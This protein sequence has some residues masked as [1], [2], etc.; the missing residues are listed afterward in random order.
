MQLHISRRETPA[1]Y[2][3]RKLREQEIPKKTSRYIAH[4]L[5]VKF[6]PKGVFVESSELH[7]NDVVTTFNTIIEQRWNQSYDTEEDAALVPE[8]S[9]ALG[10]FLLATTGVFPDMFLIRE[11]RRGAPPIAFY[12]GMGALGYRTAAEHMKTGPEQRVIEKLSCNFHEAR[13]AV[14]RSLA[15]NPLRTPLHILLKRLE[16]DNDTTRFTIYDS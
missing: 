6:Q 16:L 1:P 12:E 5:G 3:Y 10:D 13:V 14:T 7:V 15:D 2:F 11:E 4:L 8:L 9:Q